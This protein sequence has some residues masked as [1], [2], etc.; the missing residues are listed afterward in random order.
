MDFKSAELGY[1]VTIDATAVDLSQVMVNAPHTDLTGGGTAR[2]RGFKPATMF[3]EL[4]FAFGPSRI[5][6]I[7][8]DSIAVKAQLADG[9]ANVARARGARLGRADRPERAVRAGRGT[10]RHAEL[11]RRRSTRSRRSRVS[12][13]RASRPD[14]GV[15]RPRPRIAAEAVQRARVESARIARQTEVQRAI[16]GGTLP[17]IQVDTPKAIPRS[18]IAGTV[19]A[20][21]TIAGSIERFN[22]KGVGERHRARRC[23]ATRRDTS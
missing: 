1:D 12:S 3:S 15:V 23:A 19:R 17:R 20:S 2:G 16:S 6:T 9:L 13:R 8:V 7:A 5:D 14:T 22:L 11:Q 10:H 21:G 4:D 18:L